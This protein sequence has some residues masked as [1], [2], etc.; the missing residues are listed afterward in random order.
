MNDPISSQSSDCE[1]SEMN[2]RFAPVLSQADESSGAV[3]EHLPRMGRSFGW[4][5]A[6]FAVFALAAF[7]YVV[8]YGVVLGIEYAGQG[9]MAPDA[10]EVESQ[11]MQHLIEP[12][13]IVGVYLVQCLLLIPMIL[14]AANFS[15]Q[16]WRETLGFKR[17][18]KRHAIFWL[19]V[20]M[21]YFAVEFVVSQV[22]S[23]DPGDF[24]RSLS[25]SKHLPAAF[26]LVI[27]APLLE[28]LIFRGYLFKAWRN[29]RLGLSG[30]LLLTSVLFTALHAGQYNLTILAMIFS[31][32]IILGLAR[33]KS[34]SIWVP[35]LIHATN[36][37]VAAVTVIYFGW[38]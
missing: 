30:T 21:V 8:G 25:N 26:V 35:I 7:L 12:S 19:L 20:W 38:L 6:F 17:F 5:A 11:V 27:C 22:F 29:S 28:E 2:S 15:T 13:G 33:E 9:N 3:L 10:K 23:V 36:N 32:S 31:L 24:M 18:E 37:L 34:G 1:S 16:S 14:L 4:L